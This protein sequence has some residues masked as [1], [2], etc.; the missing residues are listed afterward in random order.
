MDKEFEHHWVPSGW[1]RGW[2]KDDKSYITGISSS[3]PA[4]HEGLIEEDERLKVAREMG[5]PIVQEERTIGEKKYIHTGI[6]FPNPDDD[7]RQ[8]TNP[9]AEEFYNRLKQFEKRGRE[10]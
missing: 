1:L 4:E 10:E 7:G 2:K 8:S 6:A 3:V 5:L 9:V